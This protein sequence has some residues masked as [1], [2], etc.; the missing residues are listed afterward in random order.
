MET[1]SRRINF[2]KI[3]ESGFPLLPR[4]SPDPSPLS[5]A[6]GGRCSS[7]ANL[8]AR[9]IK[10]LPSGKK[11]LRAFVIQHRLFLTSPVPPFQ[12]RILHYRRDGSDHDRSRRPKA[13]VQDACSMPSMLSLMAWPVLSSENSQRTPSVDCVFAPLATGTPWSK[14]LA[15]CSKPVWPAPILSRKISEKPS[16]GASLL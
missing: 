9:T 1:M 15:S 3:L 12:R 14:R 8:D 5:E 7:A 11:G 13:G 4:P 6:R 10:G 16:A 2:W